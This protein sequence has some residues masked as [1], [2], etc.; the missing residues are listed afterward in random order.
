MPH[1][2]SLPFRTVQHFPS[3]S[4]RYSATLSGLRFAS[5]CAIRAPSIFG[6]FFAIPPIFRRMFRAGVLLR[7]R[8]GRAGPYPL[9]P[10]VRGQASSRRRASRSPLLSIRK[11]ER[12]SPPSGLR[13]LRAGARPARRTGS[14]GTDSARADSPGT[15]STPSRIP[16]DHLCARRRAARPPNRL[17]HVLHERPLLSARRRAACRRTLTPAAIASP[18]PPSARRRAACRR[19]LTPAAIASSSPP[20][21]RRHLPAHADP[22]SHRAIVSALCSPANRLSCRRA[23]SPPN[24]LPD[25][26]GPRRCADPGRPV[27]VESPEIRRFAASVRGAPAAGRPAGLGDTGRFA[28]TA[29]WFESGMK[30]GALH[31]FITDE[32]EMEK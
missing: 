7:G 18:S 27:V 13:S 14:T 26:A 20:S 6:G 4:F 15:D 3:L 12:F 5:G 31:E 32:T 16:P 28:T 8:P 19:T 21:A 1:C 9:T 30:F 17:P 22:G 24:R 10:G 29:G 23:A 2:P 25:V 11:I